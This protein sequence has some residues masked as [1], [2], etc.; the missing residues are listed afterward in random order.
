MTRTAS[1]QAGRFSPDSPTLLGLTAP[2]AERKAH[3]ITDLPGNLYAAILEAEKSEMVR[4]VLGDHV[5]EKFIENKKIEWDDYRTHISQF[6]ID[7]YLPI[8]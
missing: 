1:K 2:P 5:F 3:G 7:K 8:L 6:E 4:D